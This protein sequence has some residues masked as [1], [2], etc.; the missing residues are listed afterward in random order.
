MRFDRLH[1]MDT[2]ERARWSLRGTLA[3]DCLGLVYEGLSPSRIEKR[4]SESPF[5]PSFIAGRTIPSDDT[6]HAYLTAYA[7]SVSGDEPE[8]F[9]RILAREIRKWFL[10]LPFGIGLATLKA[11]V[12]LSVGV[13]P[14]RSAVN[15]AGNGACMRAPVIGWWYSDRPELIPS[16]A[17]ISTEITHCHPLALQGALWCARAAS[18]YSRGESLPELSSDW[19][20]DN[21]SP[22]RGATG[23]VVHTVHAVRRGLIEGLSLEQIIRQ[24]GDTDTIAAIVGGIRGAES[25]PAG[26]K[27]SGW[28]DRASIEAFQSSPSFL[29]MLRFHLA[30]YPVVIGHGLRRLI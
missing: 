22:E 14:P 13:H 2:V 24:G 18:A 3:G 25:L 30:S 11:G 28:P 8:K 1:I 5:S 16:F 17:R 4:I 20:A 23:Y 26:L 7:L 19:P 12:K 29:R 9:Q 10:A 6:A 27:V 21:H 15:S